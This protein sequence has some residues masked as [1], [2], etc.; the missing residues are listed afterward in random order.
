MS[1]NGDHIT[2]R[3]FLVVVAALTVV[4][5]ILTADSQIY[6]T[7]YYLLSEA[8]SILAG[9]H[10]YRDFYEWGA[11]LAAYLSAGAQILVGHRL[12]GEFALQWLFIVAGVVL[13]FRV[14]LRLSGSVAAS[15]AMVPFVL[16]ILAYTPT[17]H[18]SKLFFFP[19]TIWLAWQY[20]DGP[21]AL[22]GG[23]FGL[24]TALAFLFR[25]DY[26]VY[27]GFASVV[28]FALARVTVPASRRLECLLRDSAAY[29]G[30][31][32]VVLAP[33]LVVVQMSEGLIEYARMRA[34]MYEE[35]AD[36]VVYSALLTLNPARQLLPEPPPPPTPAVVGFF[37]KP[38]TNEAQQRQLER[39][40]GLRLLAD[41]DS[42]GRLRY[43][44][45]NVYDL[46]LFALDPYITDGSGFEWD[47]LEELRDGLPT[48][49]NTALWL[50]QMSLL[51]PMLLLLSAAVGFWRSRYR[52]DTPLRADA[53]RMLLAG[54]FLALVDASLFRQPSYMTTVAPVTAAL[55]ARFLAARSL[56]VRSGAIVALLLTSFAA[57]VWTRD[58]VI[59]RPSQFAHSVSQAFKQLWP[60]PPV[61]GSPSQSLR[62]LYQ[63][64]VPGDRLL[65]TGSTPY[66]VSYYAQRPFAG[67]HLFWNE[68]WR[69]DPLH[70]QQLLALIERQSVPFAFSTHDPVMEE[71][72]RYSKIWQ[73]LED[74]YLEV[75]GFQGRLLIDK[76]RQPTGTFG[77]T[78]LPC[79]R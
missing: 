2:H 23:V 10:P 7:N 43:E 35:P 57:F 56:T 59:Y 15:L 14:G 29:V 19:L 42:R 65:V 16:V 17:Y 46:G 50:E 38:E 72:K 71:F 20:M 54:S 1:G 76:R 79:F 28:A 74:N 18:Y 55:S 9:D 61:D 11:L 34:A 13:S 77:P 47:R 25:H 58:S 63:C 5:L 32:A 37:W 75:E 30:V 41:R 21:T 8:T 78:A 49:D 31:V 4:V 70:Q 3:A 36:R 27:I 22:R 67:G 33:W 24:M 6:D 51:V 44:V 62:Y 66:Q 39:Q 26:G 52:S 12:I 45:A 40:V 68:G 64:T 60:S 69:S 53:C 73:Y 48:H